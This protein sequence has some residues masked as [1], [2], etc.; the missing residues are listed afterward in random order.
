MKSSIRTFLILEPNK[1]DHLRLPDRGREPKEDKETK[2]RSTLSDR[3]NCRP[4]AK[5]GRRKSSSKDQE[6]I[7]DG[8]SLE[9]ISRGELWIRLSLPLLPLT[10]GF[11]VDSLMVRSA[12]VFDPPPLLPCCRLIGSHSWILPPPSVGSS[13]PF[14]YG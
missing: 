8:T 14:L 13:F 6:E 5:G 12:L 11:C 1:N 9:S 10:V 2:A 7:R 4:Q 3:G